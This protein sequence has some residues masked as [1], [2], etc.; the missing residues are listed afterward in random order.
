MNPENPVALRVL[1]GFLRAGRV[2]DGGSSVLLL[3]TVVLAL[4]PRPA[5]GVTE[6]AAALA[7]GL[8]EKYFA[9]RVAL[10]AEFFALLCEQPAQTGA[11]DAAL[12]EFLS[13]KIVPGR[14]MES[15]W[16]GA[17]RL[18]KGQG[19]AVAVQAVAVAFV[20]IAAAGRAL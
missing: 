16:R 13:R 4:A 20:A 7:A 8:L 14:S 11:F 2:L 15:R 9:W 12:G 3:G 1:L 6:I 17:Q 10:D 5:L 19:A 18:L